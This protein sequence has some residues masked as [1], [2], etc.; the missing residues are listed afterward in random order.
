VNISSPLLWWCPVQVTVLAILAL[1][2]DALL[3]RR[4]P[5]A[6]ALVAASALIAVVG[7]TAGALSP[8][9][10]WPVAWDRLPWRQAAPAIDGLVDVPA[11]EGGLK[12][13]SLKTVDDEAGDGTPLQRAKIAV[14]PADKFLARSWKAIAGH[15][16]TILAVFYLVGVGAMVLRFGLGLAAVRGYRRHARPVCN[17]RLAGLLDLVRE[18]LGE[19]RV[20]ELRESAGLGTPATIGWRRPIVLLPRDWTEWTDDE[21]RAV[22]AHEVE[23]IR[24]RDFSSWIVAQIGIALHFYH[25]LVHS[26]AARLRLKQEL[27]ADAAAARVVGGQQKYVATLAAMALREADAVIAWPARAFLP[28]SKTFLRRIEMLHRSKS[29][30]TDFSRPLVFMTVALVAVAALC[31]AGVRGSVASDE[32]PAIALNSAAV[33]DEASPQPPTANSAENAHKTLN[34]LRNLTLAMHNYHDKHK[35]FPP[36]VVIGPDGKTPHSWRVELLPDLGQKAL[37]DDYRQNEPWD[38]PANKAVLEKMPEVFRSPFDDPKSTNSGYYVFVGPGTIFEG[39]YGIDISLITDGTS[40]TIL[41]VESKQ[42][43]PWTRPDDIPFDADKP[44]PKLDGFVEGQICVALADGSAHR[45]AA[46]KIKGQLKWLIVRNDGNVI[47]LSQMGLGPKP[48]AVGRNR[49]RAADDKA[50]Q[51][52]DNLKSLGLAMH[53]Y[54]D[55]HAHFPPAVVMGPDGKTPHSWRVDLLPFVDQKAIYAQ[56]RMNEPWDSSDNLRVL[57]QMPDVFKSPFDDAKSLNSGYFA[58]VGPGTVF[59]GTKGVRIADI[60]DGTSN[61]LM[62]VEAKRNIPWTKPEDIQFDADKPLPELGGFVEGKFA[63]VIAD[64]SFRLFDSDQVKDDLKWL[65]MRNDGHPIR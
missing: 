56:Y 35:H 25:P 50:G 58:L 40:N 41:V 51:T 21:C 38:S 10:S 4:R 7:L 59:D 29:L 16:A 33:A 17:R 30:R 49:P 23:H 1:G 19:R 57:A 52:K 5:A 27:A 63:A 64:G 15:W 14:P 9:P 6:G 37:Y 45:F 20:I 2:L 3:G 26:L 13:H 31:A 8:W 47:D 11:T 18:Q 42:N 24:R 28:T 61:T 39:K 65:I 22:L 36:A 55:I 32:H 48:H 53:I 46:D 34:N 44:L 54:H 12:L 60:T 62:I 43:V